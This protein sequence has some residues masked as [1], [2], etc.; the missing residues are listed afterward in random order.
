MLPASGQLTFELPQVKDV[1]PIREGVARTTWLLTSGTKNQPKDV[2]IL[3]YGQSISA[4]EWWLE[5]KEF[6]KAQY[7]LAR[8]QVVNKAIGGF[9]AERL[10]LTAANDIRFF[11]P[12]LILFHDYGNEN[13][14]ET[15]IQI[16]RKQTTAEIAVQTDHMALQNQEWHDRHSELWLPALC[17]T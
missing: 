16:I 5:V 13:D 17:S 2:R 4:Q 14:Y 3:V 7:P 8:I 12:D 15:I 9:S 6:L 1:T 10:K 11:Y